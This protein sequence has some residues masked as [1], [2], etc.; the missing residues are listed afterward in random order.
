MT[1]GK[2]SQK[3]LYVLVEINR[4][5]TDAIQSVTGCSLGKR[6]MCWKDFGIMAATYLNLETGQAVRG[7]PPWNYPGSFQKKILPGN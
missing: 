4:C 3:K 2:G 6:S 7:L 1:Q 5:A